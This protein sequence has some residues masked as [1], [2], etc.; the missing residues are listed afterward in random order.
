MYSGAWGTYVFSAIAAVASSGTILVTFC[1]E[2]L[3]RFFH[4]LQCV[5]D[6]KEVVDMERW[7][8]IRHAS[9]RG[10]EGGLSAGGAA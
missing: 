10:K 5:L 8:E 7:L 3:L 4:L 2:Y 6:L 9:S 1:T